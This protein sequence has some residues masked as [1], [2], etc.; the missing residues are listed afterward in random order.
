ME[1][2]HLALGVLIVISAL[3]TIAVVVKRSELGALRFA[4]AWLTALVIL[5][6]LYKSGVIWA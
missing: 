3:V 6:I 1:G 4:A 2:I 5:V